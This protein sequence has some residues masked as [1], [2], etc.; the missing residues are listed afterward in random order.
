MSDDRA[1]VPAPADEGPGPGTLAERLADD[2]ARLDTELSE[3]ELLVT[4]ATAEAGRHESRRAAA[5]DKLE[6]LAPDATAERLDVTTNLVTLTKR[7]A[8]METQVD[9][10]EGKRR[11][12]QRYRDLNAV[13]PGIRGF[14][15][16]RPQHRLV[17]LDLNRDRSCDALA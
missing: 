9:V 16:P 17:S 5:A 10:L 11:A 1:M 8:L 14:E 15:F 3:I 7:A 4:Q 12:L 6:A 2:L 13:E